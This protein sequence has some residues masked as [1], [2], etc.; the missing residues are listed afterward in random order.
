M[1]GGKKR[2]ADTNMWGSPSSSNSSS[3]RKGASSS[4]RGGSGSGGGSGYGGTSSS[5]SGINESKA[6][7]IFDELTEEDDPGAANMEG[8]LV[9]SIMFACYRYYDSFYSVSL[10]LTKFIISMTFPYLLQLSRNMQTM[11]TTRSRSPRGCPCPRS[12]VETRCE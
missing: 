8:E 7:K 4:R 2:K 12:P 1:A 9:A 5:T 3:R 11:R 10:S 6:E